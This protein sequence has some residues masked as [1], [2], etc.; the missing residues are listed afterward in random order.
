[1]DTEKFKVRLRKNQAVRSSARRAM[2]ERR[3]KAALRT[4]LAKI[5]AAKT[6]ET[7]A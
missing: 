7:T 3:R 2:D 4:L 6:L 5:A 1:M